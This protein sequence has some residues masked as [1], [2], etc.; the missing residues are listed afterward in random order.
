MA[1]Q[2]QQIDAAL[3]DFIGRQTIFFVASAA[4]GS[5][6]NL[7][8]RSTA[9]FRVLDPLTIAYLDKTGSGN[10][11]AAHIHAGGRVTIM[12]CAFSGPPMILRLYGTGEIH[13]RRSEGYRS[14]VEQHFGGGAPPGARQVVSLSATRVQTSCGFGVPLLDYRGERDGLDKWAETQGQSGI[15]TYWRDRNVTS[16]DGLPTHI[17]AA[18]LQDG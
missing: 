12:F 16:L 18:N 7:S 3:R 5:H 2:H 4:A 6:V 9:W 17:L 15:E 11:T 8:P 10:E 14:I 13:G 1:R